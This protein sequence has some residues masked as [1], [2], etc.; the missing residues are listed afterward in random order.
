MDSSSRNT[1]PGEW[2]APA[3]SSSPKQADKSGVS[4]SALPVFVL[5]KYEG[6]ASENRRQLENTQCTHSHYIIVCQS[7]GWGKKRREEI[8]R[9]QLRRAM[10]GKLILIIMCGINIFYN[11]Q[12]GIR[13]LEYNILLR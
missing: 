2:A 5:G 6:A 12:H 8:I 1:H 3:R 4:Y 13:M 10:L 11:L 9:L 7:V